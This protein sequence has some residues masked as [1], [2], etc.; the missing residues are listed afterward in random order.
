LRLCVAVSRFWDVRGYL[1]EGRAR[2]ASLLARAATGVPEVVRAAA[3][4]EATHLAISQS[5]Y[6]LATAMAEESLTLAREAGNQ[7]GIAHA[8]RL[9]GHLSKRSGNQA[10]AGALFA[11]SLALFR[12]LDDRP[13]I[14]STLGFMTLASGGLTDVAVERALV[15]ESLALFREM[16]DTLSIAFRLNTL[17]L[18]ERRAGDD[19]AAT[20]HYEE[21]LT[22]FREVGSKY[23][24]AVVLNNLG[25]LALHQGDDQR[26]AALYKEGFAL[27]QALG[28]DNEGIPHILAALGGVAVV[29]RQPRRAARLFGAMA[30]WCA[31]NNGSQLDEATFAA[32]W[33]AGRVLPLEEAIAY[34]LGEHASL[35]DV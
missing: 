23:G 20:S 1:T 7:A 14:A 33:A 11:E 3:L 6:A 25:H 15:E 19:R 21:A 26:A 8:L 24:I 10:M 16:G 31:A 35:T 12:A 4:Q 9:L 5:D 17:G 30:A 22:L 13:G 34:A 2:L 29:R 27:A 18:I 28:A 32:A